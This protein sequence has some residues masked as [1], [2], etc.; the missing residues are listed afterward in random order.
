[1]FK[2]HPRL[3]AMISFHT[4]GDRDSLHN[5]SHLRPSNSI[6]QTVNEFRVRHIDG[7]MNVWSESLSSLLLHAY[8][9]K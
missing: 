8:K 2:H 3:D 1:M 9:T 6:V 4:V 5:D 7:K